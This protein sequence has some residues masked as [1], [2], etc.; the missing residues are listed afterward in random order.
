MGGNINGGPG[1]M[2]QLPYGANS[3]ILSSGMQSAFNTTNNN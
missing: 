2:I 1:N 3:K